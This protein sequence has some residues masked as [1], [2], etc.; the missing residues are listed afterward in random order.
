[1]SASLHC[2]TEALLFNKKRKDDG[3]KALSR[4]LHQLNVQ[5]DDNLR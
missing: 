2:I 1:M 3:K 4:W 5:E